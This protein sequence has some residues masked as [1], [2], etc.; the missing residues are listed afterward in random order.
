MDTRTQE[1]HT[2]ASVDVAQHIA[3]D[4]VTLL[5][6]TQGRFYAASASTPDRL[7]LLTG[8]SCQCA[9]FAYRQSCR[10]HRA[11][12]TAL[13][14]TEDAPKRLPAKKPAPKKAEPDPT[15]PAPLEVRCSSCNGVGSH[16]ATV[17]TGPHSFTYTNVTCDRCHGLGVV[18]MPT[19]A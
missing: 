6:S 12:M 7:Y 19:A 8:F 13:G 15:T 17:S 9:G 5:R 11:L 4:G 14:W 10:H 2:E 18:K 1:F 16:P 3:V